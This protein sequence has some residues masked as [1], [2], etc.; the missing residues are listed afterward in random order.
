MVMRISVGISRMVMVDSKLRWHRVTGRAPFQTFVWH[1]LGSAN[2]IWTSYRSPFS[3]VVPQ[4]QRSFFF[5]FCLSEI[6]RNWVR[7]ILDPV[8]LVLPL[9][10]G[11]KNDFIISFFIWNTLDQEVGII[12]INVLSTITGAGNV[13]RHIGSRIRSSSNSSRR[14]TRDSPCF[15]PCF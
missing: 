8:L 6:N 5:L 12:F 2:K 9:H 15:R 14:S 7:C 4:N 11:W 3:N 10:P 13:G 1:T